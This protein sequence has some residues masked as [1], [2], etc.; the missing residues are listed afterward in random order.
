MATKLRER[1]PPGPL[2]RWFLRAP[3]WLYEHGLGGLLGQRFLLLRHVG[4]KSGLPR[5]TVLEV[6]DHDPASDTYYVA[7]GFGPHSHWFKN[8]QKAPGRSHRRGSA[9][10][11]RHCQDPRAGAGGCVD[12]ELRR[13]QPEGCPRARQGDGLRGRRQP[14]G[15][16]T[17][18]RFGLAVRRARTACGRLSVS[19]RSRAAAATRL[20]SVCRTRRVGRRWRSRS[21]GRRAALSAQTARDTRGLNR[22][23]R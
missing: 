6:V 9:Q 17:A 13:A 5:R 10:P 23:A 12:G 16:S 20:G 14:G 15:L 19:A 3:I 11:E 4:A 7:V 2:L 1:Q 22:C 18:R 8:L 21:R